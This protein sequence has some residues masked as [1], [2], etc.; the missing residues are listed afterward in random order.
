MWNQCSSCCSIEALAPTGFSQGL[1][2]LAPALC[3][4]YQR[5]A[6]SYWACD[7]IFPVPASILA[8]PSPCYSLLFLLRTCVIG[9]KAQLNL[10]CSHLKILHLI[11]SSK[12]FSPNKVTFTGLLRAT[13]QPIK[14][15]PSGPGGQATILNPMMSLMEQGCGL[16]G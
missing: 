11:T 4:Q 1:H 10:G 14:G 3:Q 8:W 6:F 13:I 7:H 9:F 16:Q 2:H 15:P 5:S 12:T